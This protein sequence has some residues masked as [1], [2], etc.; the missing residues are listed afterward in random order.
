MRAEHYGEREHGSGYRNPYR[1][2][3]SRHFRPGFRTFVIGDASYDYY[4]SLPPDY[5]TV[6]INGI[7]YYL[8]EGVYYQAYLYDGQTVYVA[9]PAPQ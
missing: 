7:T 5:Q 4:D 2:E 9:V 1:D 8:F 6:V 3:Y